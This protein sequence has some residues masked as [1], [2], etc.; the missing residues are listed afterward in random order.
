M[1]VFCLK[2]LN[3]LEEFIPAALQMMAK[4]IKAQGYPSKVPLTTSRIESTLFSNINLESIVESS[5][6]LSKAVQVSLD[7]F[8]SDV[9][10]GD[11]LWHSKESDEYG[12]DLTFISKS[13]GG[14][15]ID[16]AAIK[17]IENSDS[18]IKEMTMSSDP[19][20]CR[21]GT[22]TVRVAFK[23]FRIR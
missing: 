8:F 14:F 15:R 2:R 6:T 16:H 18:P 12:I 21:H 7:D 4:I 13:L 9:K 3:K 10:L 11:C 23:V 5:K 17:L 20:D 22:N 1:Y 19:F